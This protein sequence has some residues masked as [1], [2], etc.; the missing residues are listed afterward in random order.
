MIGISFEKWNSFS[1]KIFKHDR[2]FIRGR[3][4]PFTRM[5]KRYP[6]KKRLLFD[7]VKL[8]RVK[9]IQEQI[10][11]DMADTM[12]PEQREYKRGLVNGLKAAEKILF[13]RDTNY[14]R[15]PGGTDNVQGLGRSCAPEQM[16]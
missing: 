3:W 1:G 6:S 7:R 9:E 11:Q 15:K 12:S 5:R 13:H 10:Y 4:T 2:I 8:L 16:E 14:V